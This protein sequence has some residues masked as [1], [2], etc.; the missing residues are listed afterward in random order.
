LAAFEL[1][2]TWNPSASPTEALTYVV[3]GTLLFEPLILALRRLAHV[4]RGAK[5][6]VRRACT[7]APAPDGDSS[8]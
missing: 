1:P 7:A 5:L 8:A 2:D 4:D 6:R 3:Q